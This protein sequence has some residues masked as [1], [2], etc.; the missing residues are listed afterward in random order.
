[1]PER[2]PQHQPLKP[3]LPFHHLIVDLGENREAVMHPLAKHRQDPPHRVHNLEGG[4][5][6]RHDVTRDEKLRMELRLVFEEAQVFLPN[7]KVVHPL[8]AEEGGG[9][10]CHDR[11]D[12]DGQDPVDIPRALDHDHHQGDGGALHPPEHRARPRQRVRPREDAVVDVL[13]REL[14]DDAANAAADERA[15]EEDAAREARAPRQRH[16]KEVDERSDKHCFD[17]ERRPRPRL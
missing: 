8:L 15:R 3:P 6:G 2:R 10:V 7:A 9:E 17:R 14:A 1:M 12:H 11:R 5:G 16:E 4:H 13:L